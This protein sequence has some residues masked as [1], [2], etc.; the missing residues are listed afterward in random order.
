MGEAEKQ[1]AAEPTQPEPGKAPEVE[2][3]EAPDNPWDAIHDEIEI[4]GEPTEAESE[5]ETEGDKPAAE[6][7]A[8]PV[9][10]GVEPTPTDDQTPPKPSHYE[11]FD[12]AGKPVELQLAVGS[13]L[14]FKADKSRVEVGSVD[15]LVQLAQKGIHYTSRMQQFG[16]TEAA[17]KTEIGQLENTLREG[18]ELM[19]KVL[20]DREYAEELREKAAHLESPEARAGLRAT[21]ELKARDEKETADAQTLEAKGREKLWT[22]AQAY[23][24]TTLEEHESLKPEDAEG[25]LKGWYSRYLVVR[26]Q[27]WPHAIAAAEKAGKSDTE[28]TEFAEAVAFRFLNRTSLDA[29]ILEAAGGTK[30]VPTPAE[31][32]SEEEAKAA[33]DAHNAAVEDKKSAVATA[34]ATK[35][36]K[37]AVPPAVQPQPE[38]TLEE[39]RDLTYKERLQLMRDTLAEAGR[40]ST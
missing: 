2:P 14:R 11:V 21:Q 28:S 10:E 17:L 33:V 38:A 19:L 26:E 36:G 34:R 39:Q 9:A 18:E 22:D 16:Q 37:T 6:P 20:F 4:L 12:E 24:E 13:K 8:T 35:G 32:V 31:G 30:A 25:V 15:E 5:A 7:A 23:V 29:V 1:V 40:P 27:V 3:P